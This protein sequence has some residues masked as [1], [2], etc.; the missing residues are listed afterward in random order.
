MVYVDY[1]GSN[2]IE[3][4]L[5]VPKSHL[6]LISFLPKVEK[7]INFKGLGECSLIPPK[8]FDSS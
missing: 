3:G 1:Q 2:A 5:D 7:R 4:Y 6:F 8:N